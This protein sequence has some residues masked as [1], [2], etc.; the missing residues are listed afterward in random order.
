HKL[1]TCVYQATRNSGEVTY[2][3]AKLLAEQ[4]GAEFH[5]LEVDD[6][7]QGYTRLGEQVL[8][9]PLT[10]EQDD[11]ALQNVQ[12]RPRSPGVWLIANLQNAL[13]LCTSNRSEAAVGYATMDGDTSGGLCPISGI[14]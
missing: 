2:G 8:G 14:D 4:I 3:A 6:L 12:A 9:R 5:R 13:L 1:L 10:W 7:V 11:L